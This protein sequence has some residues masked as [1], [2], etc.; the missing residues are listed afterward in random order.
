MMAR[1]TSFLLVI[2]LV[3]IGFF[4]LHAQQSTSGYCSPA[5]NNVTGNV[6]T[7]CY[8]T[9]AEW[10]RGVSENLQ[11]TIFQLRQLSSAQRF[12]MMPT[13]DNYVDNPS[14]TA[15]NSAR[16]DVTRVLQKLAIAIDAAIKYD[17]SLQVGM[18]PDLERVH[19][20]LRSRADLFDELPDAPPSTVYVQG[21]AVR[22][23]T[24]M[25]R[26]ANQ[27]TELQA[28]LRQVSTP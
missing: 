14:P 19:N 10:Q 23:R 12:Y 5:I 1:T 18:G 13:M 7:I 9:K 16:R 27:L 15:W 22:Y 25:V 4:Q 8:T 3:P 2:F 24:Q 11:E 28:K 6:T 21:W 20:I 17:G 26:L